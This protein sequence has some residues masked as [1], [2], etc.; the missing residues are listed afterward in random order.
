MSCCRSNDHH[1]VAEGEEAVF[2]RHR[3]F[4]N[5]QY[6]LAGAE[7]GD[8]HDERAFGQVEVGDEGVDALHLVGRVQKDARIARA[9]VQHPL[10][11]RDRLQRAHRSRAHGDDAPPFALGGIDLR[12]RAR[13]PL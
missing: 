11:V 2:F 5:V 3:R 12:D 10:F 9:G 6:F 4:V 1:R 13:S 8:E 7:A